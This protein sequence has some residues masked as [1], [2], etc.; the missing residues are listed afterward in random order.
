LTNQLLPL[1]RRIFQPKYAR[2][3]SA[4]T[5]KTKQMLLKVVSP[6]LVHPAFAW[7]KAM[8][9]GPLVRETSYR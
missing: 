8:F 7:R 4:A 3:T 2:A 6:V 5:N 9:I 1:A